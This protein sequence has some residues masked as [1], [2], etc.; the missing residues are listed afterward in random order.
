MKPVAIQRY[1]PT[2]D[3]LISASTSPRTNP[4]VNAQA[5]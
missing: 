1:G 4:K 2:G 3:S 5:V